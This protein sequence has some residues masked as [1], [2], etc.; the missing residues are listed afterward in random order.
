MHI[1]RY[2]RGPVLSFVIDYFGIRN[3]RDLSTITEQN[4][5]FRQLRSVLKGLQVLLMH[6]GRIRT[7][8]SIVLNAGNV[9]RAVLSGVSSRIRKVHEAASET[10]AVLLEEGP[11]RIEELANG[12]FGW[13]AR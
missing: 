13:Q 2:Q 8:K 7:I 3:L 11:V 5:L 10:A 12:W 4:P 9:K 6:S 1:H